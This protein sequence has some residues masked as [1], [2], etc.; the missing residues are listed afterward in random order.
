[1]LIRFFRHV[2]FM[3]LLMFSLLLLIVSAAMFFACRYYVSLLLTPHFFDAAAFHADAAITLRFIT[4]CYAT[5]P[6]GGFFVALHADYFDSYQLLPL[7]RCRLYAA[8]FHYYAAFAACY[9]AADAAVDYAFDVLRRAMLSPCF[10][11]PLRCHDCLMF[12]AFHC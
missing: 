6:Y 10:T 11:A 7:L 8:D 9:A 12:F 4:P 3:L 1:M 2:F 5:L